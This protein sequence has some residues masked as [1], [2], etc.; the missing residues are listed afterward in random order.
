MAA[1]PYDQASRYLAKLD[2]PPFLAWLLRLRREAL[3]FRRWLDARLVRFPGEPDRTCD[4]VAFLEDVAAGGVPWALVLEFQI[5]P[6]ALMFGRLLGYAGSL[7][8]EL[9]PSPERGDRFHVGAVV[10]NL[11][12]QGDCSRDLAWPEAGLRT[13]LTVA[14]RNLSTYDAAA[15]LEDITTGA[16]P[17]VVLPLVALMKGGSESAIIERWKELA[18]QETDARRRAD[19]GGLV[20]V[21]AEAAGCRDVWKAALKEWNVV[22]SQQ[23]LEWQAEAHIKGKAETLLEMLEARFGS[24]PID[25]SERVLGIRDVGRLKQLAVHV[26]RCVSLQ[27]F[28]SELSK[29]GS[30]TQRGPGEKS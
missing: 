9:K 14:E 19:Y 6:D 5:E 3:A 13:N 2:P 20:L 11:T 27:E 21:F 12:G 16:A 18:G 17:A 15:V 28:Q 22:Q 4:T 10:V 7:W 25:V 23:V 8:L 26:M 1:N 29:E 24:V 30:G